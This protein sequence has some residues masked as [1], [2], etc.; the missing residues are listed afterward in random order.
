MR[1]IVVFNLLSLDGYFAEEDGNI[2]WHQV[3]DE[4]N[5]FAIE[6]T[7]SFGG[8]IFGKTTYKIFED[9]WPQALKD[10][11]TS[12]DDRK[13]A[14]T[15]DDIWK[16]VFSKSLKEVTWKNSKLYHEIDPEEIKKWK[17]NDGKDLAIFGSGTIVQQFTNLSLV[18]EYRFLVNPIVLGKGKPMFANLKE[19]L[20]LKLLDTRTFGNGNILLTYQPDKGKKLS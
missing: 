17:E 1:K 3:D 4:F 9:F 14:Q 6:Q 13:I 10:P 7:A 18:D 2:D 16:I 20:K 19:K 8:I 5:Q 12:P 11:K 15:I